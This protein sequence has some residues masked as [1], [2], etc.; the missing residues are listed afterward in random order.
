M[1]SPGSIRMTKQRVHRARPDPHGLLR[2]PTYSNRREVK[3]REKMMIGG[4]LSIQPPNLSAGA[5]VYRG[6]LRCAHPST[7][8][9]IWVTA[10]THLAMSVG[11][12][13]VDSL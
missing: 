2:R 9:W 5:R 1:K 7:T 6:L 10:S 3:M 8:R 4:R 11:D 13:P 12:M